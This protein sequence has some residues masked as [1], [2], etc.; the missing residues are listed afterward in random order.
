MHNLEITVMITVFTIIAEILAWEIAPRVFVLY[1]F[2]FSFH[3]WSQAI[4]YSDG[5]WKFPKTFPPVVMFKGD[6]LGLSEKCPV[7]HR[8]W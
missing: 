3:V 4:M 1:N 6:N 5:F 8:L 7:S 2:S